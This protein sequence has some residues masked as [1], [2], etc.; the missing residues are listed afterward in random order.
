[1]E[2][3]RSFLVNSFASAFSRVPGLIMLDSPS[4]KSTC[5]N[6]LTDKFLF[7]TTEKSPRFKYCF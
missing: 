7:T 5:S 4:D 1:M 6:V 3:K 2:R